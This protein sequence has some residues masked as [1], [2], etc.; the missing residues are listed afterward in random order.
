MK[1]VS[2]GEVLV[3]ETEFNESSFNLLKNVQFCVIIACAFR[4]SQLICVM[5]EVGG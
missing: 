4:N 5:D 1:F 3:R 2:G